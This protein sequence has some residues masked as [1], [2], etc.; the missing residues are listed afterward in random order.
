MLSII[1]A[2]LPILAKLIPDGK[3]ADIVAAGTKVALDVFGTTDEAS[4]VAKL[5]ADPALAE[6]FKAKLEAETATLRMQIEDTQDARATTVKLAQ[7][8]SNIAWGAPV[9]SVLIVLGF[10]ALVFALI[11]KQV[12][13]SQAVLML[14]GTLSTS[15][16]IVVSYWLGSSAGSARAGDTVRAIAQQATTPTAGQVAGKVID[17]AVNAGKR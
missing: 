17:A 1:L 11:F 9:I 5:E 8:G 10:L 7:A 13:D 15:F 16:G 6:Q 4:I 2:A 3:T 12:P 14:F